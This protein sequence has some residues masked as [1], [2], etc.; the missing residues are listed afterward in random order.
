[1]VICLNYPWRNGGIEMFRN[2][3]TQPAGGEA[4]CESR[5][6]APGSEL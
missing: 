4:Q 1:M 6:S 2:V 5:Q 3:F